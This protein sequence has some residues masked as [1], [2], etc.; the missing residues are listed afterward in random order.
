MPTRLRQVS[1]SGF[2]ANL[3]NGSPPILLLMP[4]SECCLTAPLRNHI[5]W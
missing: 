3:R 4:G 1:G 5:R 2:D